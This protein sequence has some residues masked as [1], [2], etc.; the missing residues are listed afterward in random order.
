MIQSIQELPV[1]LSSNSAPPYLRQTTLH[2]TMFYINFDWLTTELRHSIAIK[3][4]L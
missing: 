4:T 1:L 2:L 3:K